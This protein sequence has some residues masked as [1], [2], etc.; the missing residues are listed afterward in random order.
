MS[1]RLGSGY[2]LT[3]RIGR[4]A[5]GE[6]WRAD[7]PDGPVAVKIL[8]PGIEQRFAA[9][10]A[11][12]LMLAH[13]RD[14][15]VFD[16]VALQGFIAHHSGNWFDRMRLELRR[17]R[18]NPEVANAVFDGYLCAVEYVLYGSTPYAE[19]ISAAREI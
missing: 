17:T 4:G 10:Q 19:V 11:Q 18:E 12:R 14:W 7:G 8:R 6:V 13:E 15:K 5:M 9:D 16:L 3:A 1:E 2:E